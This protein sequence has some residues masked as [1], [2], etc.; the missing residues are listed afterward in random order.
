MDGVE[1]LR[2]AI[3]IQAVKDYRKAYRRLLRDP[4]SKFAKADVQS[5]EKFFYSDWYGDLTDVDGALIVK[6]VRQEEEEIFQLKEAKRNERI[7]HSLPKRSHD[8][9]Y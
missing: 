9:K 6:K 4:N 8:F 5:Q 3:I 7:N 2:N 1:R